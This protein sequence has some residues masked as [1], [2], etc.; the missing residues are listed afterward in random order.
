MILV[1]LVLYVGSMQ[2]G[3]VGFRMATLLFML[4]AGGTLLCVS[5][6]PAPRSILWLAIVCTAFLLSFGLSALFTHVLVIDL[7]S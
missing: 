3:F 2:F 6:I 7:P 5:D 1:L 4:S